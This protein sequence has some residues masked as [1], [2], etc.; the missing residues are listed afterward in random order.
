MPLLPVKVV[1]ARGVRKRIKGREVLRDFSISV[2]RGSVHV[3]AGPNGA[4]K[5]T[6]IRIM[7]GLVRRDAGE[8]LVLGGDP[9]EE[10]WEAKKGLIGYL[11]EEAQPYERLTGEEHVRLFASIYGRDEGE[12][13]ERA[14]EISGLG[15]ALRARAATY[16][17][18]MKRR[19]MLALALMHGPELAVLDE[20]TGGLDVVSAFRVREIIKRM[21][22]AGTTFLITTHDLREAQQIASRVTF[23]SGGV[24]IAEGSV[25]EV[26]RAFGASSLE[27]AYV[28]AVGFEER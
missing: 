24:T 2:E 16:S 6:A 1:E 11:P 26:T 17:K 28:R 12:M 25:E 8:L 22:A 10:G 20:P 5:T 7:L 15:E 4:G 27:E 21:S 19:L 14:R 13:L 3:L 18:G 23:I 9:A